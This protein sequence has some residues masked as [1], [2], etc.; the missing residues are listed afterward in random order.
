VTFFPAERP[1]P[2]KPQRIAGPNWPAGMPPPWLVVLRVIPGRPI[3]EDFVGLKR[4][5]DEQGVAL[6]GS[7]WPKIVRFRAGD[8]WVFK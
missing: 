7:A 8:L 3:F 1:D 5:G 4:L 2:R 6:W